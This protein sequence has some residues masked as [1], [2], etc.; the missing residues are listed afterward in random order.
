M[1]WQG[2]AEIAPRLS[3]IEVRFEKRKRF[4]GLW[5]G[6][7]LFIVAVLVPPLQNASAVGMRTFGIFL[8]TVTWWIC[9]PIPIPATS[10]SSLAML[11]LSGVLS[12]DAAF[13]T[14]SNW[15]CIF[16]IGA[17]IIGH[18]MGVHGLT[19][20]I[21]YS[22]ASFRLV[23]GN[24]WRV[25]L[26]FGLGSALMSSMLSHVVT[27]MIFISI[28]AGLVKTL[29]FQQGSR[30][31]EAI[32]LAIAWGSNM[33]VVTPVAAPTNLIAVGVA[34]S[35]GYR[36]GF[37]QWV[38]I[39]LPVF[40][41]TLVAM[42]LVLR[43]VIRP[44]MPD[45]PLSPTFWAGELRKLGPLSRGEKISGG[46]FATA[47]TLWILPDVLPLFLTGGKQNPLSLWVSQHL[48]WSVTAIL[49]ATSLFLI[50]VDWKE[51]KFAMTWDEAVKGV[52]WG[53]LTLNAA[54]LGLGGAIADKKLGLGQFFEHSMSAVVSPS[55]QFLFVLA[56]VAFTVIVGAFISNIAI[57]AMVGA[58]V[59]VVA[60]AAGVNPAALMITAAIAANMD[61]ALPIGTPPSA[62]VFASGYVR[63]GSM[64]KGGTILALLSIPLVAVVGFY[65]GTWVLR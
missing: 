22:M 19:R 64:V 44:E 49:M 7:L 61:F 56:V 50:P 40:S 12:V 27:T 23:G 5:L 8:W 53:T 26:M 1:S 13:S 17:C 48:D 31:A 65:W 14:W 2:L 58:V 35:M 42:F 59:R 4:L 55:S 37:L 52:E 3:D 45:W 41:I 38:V 34:Q 46:V 60:P 57:I 18:A 25:L 11:V 10:L 51:R 9:E 43:Y 30:Y 16:L 62:L 54:A 47:M 24:P 32:F 36:I 15:I 20:R 29:G 6:P 21:A 39:C 63:I 28:A 33:G